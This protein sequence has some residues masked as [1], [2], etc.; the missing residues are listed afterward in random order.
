MLVGG[1]RELRG[2]SS[3]RSENVELQRVEVEPQLPEVRFVVPTGVSGGQVT[4]D[5]YGRHFTKPCWP[6]PRSHVTSR[7]ADRV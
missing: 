6:C 1:S 5:F 2:P 7:T 3:R 4:I